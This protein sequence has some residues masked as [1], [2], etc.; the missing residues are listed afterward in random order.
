MSEFTTGLLFLSKHKFKINERLTDKG[1]PFIIQSLNERWSG[2]FI[3]DDWL[4]KASTVDLMLELSKEVPLL[5]FQDAEDHGW[6]YRIFADGREL[7]RF[8]DDYYFDHGL[9]IE[10]AEQRYPDQGDIQLFLYEQPEGQ[11]AFS[12][13]MDEVHQSKEYHD[14]LAKSFETRNVEAFAYFDIDPVKI[15]VLE[16]LIS[17]EGLKSEP[18]REEVGIFKETLGISRMSWMSYHYLRKRQNELD[19]RR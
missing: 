9:V 16:R 13:L 17:V 11:Q 2:L 12:S 4:E 18:P 8:D 3:E 6:G 1:M 10:L 5:N 14:A 19:S 15:A 7:A